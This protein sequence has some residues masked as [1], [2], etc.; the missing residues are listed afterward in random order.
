MQYLFRLS[1]TQL[2]WSLDS[3]EF[4]LDVIGAGATASGASDWHHIWKGSTEATCVQD[5]IEAILVKGRSTS[6]VA[7]SVG[8]GFATPWV[9]QAWTLL[10]RNF[11]D[12]WRDPTYLMAKMMLNITGGLFIGFTFFKRNETLQGTQ[13]KLF[14]SF[15]HALLPREIEADLL[16]GGIHGHDPE[17]AVGQSAPSRVSANARYLRN[18]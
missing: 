16:E 7:T 4:M 2:T 12:H 18:P 17:C 13:D 6:P 1:K 11:V 8:S 9:Y 14:V 15:T 5:E 10:M 3:A